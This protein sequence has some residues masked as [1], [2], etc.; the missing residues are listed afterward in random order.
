MKKNQK[1]YSDLLTPKLGNA[2]SSLRTE[3]NEL[4]M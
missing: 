1:I 4:Y 3:E 2:G